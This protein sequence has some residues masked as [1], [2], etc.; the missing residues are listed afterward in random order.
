MTG[1]AKYRLVR[2]LGVG[3][4]AQVYEA[5]LVDR[6]QEERRIAIKRIHPQYANDPRAQRMFLDEARICSRLDHDNI[7]KLVDFGTVDGAEFIAMEFVDGVDARQAAQLSMTAGRPVPRNVALYVIAQVADA[8]HHAH[9]LT[10]SRGRCLRIVHRDATPH[11]ILLSWTGDVK[12]ADFGIAFALQREERTRTGL[13][14]GKLEYMSPE[15]AGAGTIGPPTDV[16]A[17]GPTL[18]A[19]LCGE[20]PA[21]HLFRRPDEPPTFDSAL[22]AD[23]AQLI[24][25][26]MVFDPAQRPSAAKAAE[27][28][29]RLLRRSSPPADPKQ[30]LCDWLAPLRTEL[31]DRRTVDDLFGVTLVQQSDRAFTETREADSSAGHAPAR[32]NTIGMSPIKPK[33]RATLAISTIAVLGAL[34]AF[35]AMSLDFDRRLVNTPGEAPS[36]DAG[37]TPVSINV[38]RDAADVRPDEQRLTS[39]SA[40]ATETPARARRGAVRRAARR[41]ARQQKQPRTMPNEAPTPS[42]YGWLRIGGRAL[43]GAVLEIDGRR[44]G[45]VPQEKRLRV[46][47]HH[48]VVKDSSTGATLIDQKI[49]I[50]ER[51]TRTDPRQVLRTNSER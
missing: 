17:L 27:T 46:G 33:R 5:A 47:A 40:D 35:I 14:K 25:E 11:N 18:H 13:V 43:A 41:R 10:D 24:T 31:N 32:H 26:W 1:L 44:I 50:A 6:D 23:V 7:V 19:M 22:P 39:P 42:R 48:I 20:P 16:Y 21:G 49:A 36:A 9:T 37:A 51:H 38:G 12:L 30:A 2:S 3:G 4:M 28:A 34:A 29:S 8:L 15:Q 45:F